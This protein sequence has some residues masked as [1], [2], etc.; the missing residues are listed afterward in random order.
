MQE[1]V[2]V[3]KP[4]KCIRHDF[5]VKSPDGKSDLSIVTVL[6]PWLQVKDETWVREWIAFFAQKHL[7]DNR[8]VGQEGWRRIVAR[9]VV[10][11]VVCRAL[12]LGQLVI[13]LGYEPPAW[14]DDFRE[15]LQF[16]GVIDDHRN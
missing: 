9:A 15:Y 2:C 4:V 11:Y 7:A 14:V 8:D 12:L 13:L 10:P 1:L 16:M 3:S 5:V 6:P